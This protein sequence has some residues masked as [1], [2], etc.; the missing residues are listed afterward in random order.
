[1]RK[2]EIPRGFTLLELIMTLSV[3]VI[4]LIVAVPSFKAISERGSIERLATELTGFYQHARSEAVLR[5]QT[6]FAHITFPVSTA[7]TAADWSLTL[8]DSDISG[9]GSTISVFNGAVFNGLTVHHTY[10][11]EQVSFEGIRGRAKSGT[12]A[13][14][15]TQDSSKKI[16]LRTSNPP[17]RIKVC[18][19]NGDLYGYKQC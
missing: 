15:S 9:A 14:Y 13:F 17:G 10:S 7:H 11:S 5:N 6:L 3:L 18:A 8:T 2:W 19:S 4:L 1:M 12:F 16:E